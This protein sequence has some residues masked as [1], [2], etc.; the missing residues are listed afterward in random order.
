MKWKV[1]TYKTEK[2]KSPVENFIISLPDKERARVYREIDLLEQNGIYLGYPY[3]SAI[4]GY[5]GLREL[6]VKF[7]SNQIRIIYFLYINKTFIL[8]H[9]FKKKDRR[10][11][12]KDLEIAIRRMKEYLK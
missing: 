5:K 10:L 7:S 9:G 11:S 6:R 3:T 2:G 8:L 12:K 4:R 1:E